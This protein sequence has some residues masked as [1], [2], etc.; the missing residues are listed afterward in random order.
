MIWEEKRI[1]IPE[2]MNSVLFLFLWIISR[3]E[4]DD[5]KATK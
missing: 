2:Y 5:K 4:L 3:T 1:K